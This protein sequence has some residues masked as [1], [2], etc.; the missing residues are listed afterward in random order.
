LTNGFLTDR[1]QEFPAETD[2]PLGEQDMKKVKRPMR[3]FLA[4]MQCLMELDGIAQGGGSEYRKWDQHDTVFSLT[5]PSTGPFDPEDTPGD[6][7]AQITACSPSFRSLHFLLFLSPPVYPA[8]LGGST[9]HPAPAPSHL[10]G[11]AA[12]IEVL[13]AGIRPHPPPRGATSVILRVQDVSKPR[14]DMD[15]VMMSGFMGPLDM[16][17]EFEYGYP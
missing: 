16:D 10:P 2:K 6:L 8:L 11:L 13:R 7:S 4:Y 14:S 3:G 17:A 1:I 5:D 9:T 12:P 15:N